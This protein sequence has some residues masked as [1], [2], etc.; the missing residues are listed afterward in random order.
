[1][2]NPEET[3]PPPST[4]KAKGLNLGPPG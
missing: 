4:L 3:A 2:Q 1:V